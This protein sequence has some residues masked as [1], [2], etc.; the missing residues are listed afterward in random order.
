MPNKFLLACAL[1]PAVL[2][3]GPGRAQT[4]PDAGS[5]L[6]QIE[7]ERQA[8]PRRQAVPEAAPMAPEMQ[9][10]AGVVVTVTRFAFVGNTLLDDDRLAAAVAGYLNRPLAFADLQQAAAAVAAAYRQAGWIARAYLPRQEID[11]GMVTIRIVEGRF[12][13]V[14][15][16]GAAPGSF[17]AAVALR[18]IEAHQAAG[19]PI[20]ADA[21]ERAVLLLDD[22]PGLSASSSFREGRADGET[23][24]VLKLAD[25]PV[26]A[27]NLDLDNTGSRSTGRERASLTAYLDNPAGQGEQ[28]ATNLIKTAGSRYGRLALTVPLGYDGLR[29]GISG[30]RLDFKVVTPENRTLDIK[31]IAETAGVDAAYPILRSR[32]ANLNLAASYDRKGFDNWTASGSTNR[33]RIAAASYTLSGNAFDGLWGNGANNASLTL[34]DGRVDLT[35]SAN[36]AA[37]AASTQTAG[38]YRKLKLVVSRNQTLADALSLYGQYT[39]QRASRN[40]DSSE[41]LSLGGASGVRAY[42]SGE[43]SGAEGRTLTLEAR[44]RL[45]GDINLT[46]FH[47]WGRID[48]V[49][50]NNRSPAGNV[51]ATLNAYGLRGHGLAL[52]W[53]APGGVQLKATWARR[54]AH[55]P[56]PAASGSDQDGTKIDNRIWLSASLAF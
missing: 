11:G 2:A 44:L 16:D 24:L 7:R 25:T 14:L 29:I 35:G 33:Y 32:T 13:G 9:P 5:L 34:V 22:R 55:N 18:Y 23:D 40:L 45:S 26:L 17:V 27:G 48:A 47:D 6:Q 21:V 12:G 39:A 52:G 15:F 38:P 53:L 19:A 28:L 10:A 4:V 54:E 1:L 31:G 36:Q 43:G 37:D 3:V 46:A 51:L 30:S 50:R 8:A 56:N 42:P 41:K 49:N 20:N